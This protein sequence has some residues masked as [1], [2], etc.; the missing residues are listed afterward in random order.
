MSIFINGVKQGAE[1]GLSAEQASQIISGDGGQEFTGGFTDRTTGTAGA[2]DVGSNRAYT[3]Q[4]VDNDEFMLLGI[5]STQQ[6]ANDS[7]YWS[8]PDTANM[9]DY[10]STQGLFGGTQMAA[11]VTSLFDFNDTFF[12]AGGTTTGGDP[13]LSANGSLDFSN[14]VLVGDLLQFRFDFNILP[15]IANTTIETGLIWVTRDKDTLAE[16]F[17]FHLA[18][19]SLF[20]GEGTVGSTFLQRPITTAYFASDEDVNARALPCIRSSNPCQIQP[21]TALSIIIR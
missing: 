8:S 13:Y 11:G 18:S 4:M 16:T 15:Q 12:S 14:G 7:I 21:L 3:Q 20:F 10:D 1:A 2:S 9:E 6:A 17:S 5:N 19:Q